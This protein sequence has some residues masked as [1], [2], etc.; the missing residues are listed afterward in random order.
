MKIIGVD[1]GDARTGVAISDAL[2]L[3]AQGIGT[4]YGRDAN[5]VAEKVAVYVNDNNAELVVVGL[6]KNMDGTVGFRG[7][8]TLS[9]VEIL[10]TKINCDVVMWDERLSTV[11]A[12]KTLNE[13]NTRGAKRKAV[14]DTVAAC[15]ILQN[16]LDFKGRN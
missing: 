15:I 7:D 3:T 16:Y 4:V 14:L 8:A 12:I 13:T 2:G 11:S 9:F 5:K 6:P 10:K 1:F